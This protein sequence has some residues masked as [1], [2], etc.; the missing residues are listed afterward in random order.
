MSLP[1]ALAFYL[2]IPNLGIL[3]TTHYHILQIIRMACFHLQG[4][5]LSLLLDLEYAK[6]RPPVL[7]IPNS[8]N[9]LHLY[10]PFLLDTTNLLGRT[11]SLGITS[12]LRSHGRYYHLSLAH[13]QSR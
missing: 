13:D 6:C 8:L 9:L 4:R 7:L 3:Q 2:Q 11:K 12:K 5:R 10:L 1:P